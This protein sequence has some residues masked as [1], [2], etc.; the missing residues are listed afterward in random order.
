MTRRV[1]LVTGA[2]KGIGAATA[3]ILAAEGCAVAVNYNRSKA[4][5]EALAAEIRDNGRRAAH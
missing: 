2:S 1:A 5:A 3:R 4:E